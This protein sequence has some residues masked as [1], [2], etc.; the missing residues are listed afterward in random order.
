MIKKDF[1]AAKPIPAATLYRPT[2]VVCGRRC[3][4]LAD[5]DQPVCIACDDTM[6]LALERSRFDLAPV[7]EVPKHRHV[8]GALFQRLREE[9][10]VGA[11]AS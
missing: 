7:V 4:P 5:Y 6:A 11:W 3:V 8:D 10:S 2:C 9:T 1:K